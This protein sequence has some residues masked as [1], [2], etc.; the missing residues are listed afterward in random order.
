M[1]WRSTEARPS[2]AGFTLIEVLVALSIVALALA[3]IGALVANS[4]RGTR[5]IE[6]N[7]TRLEIARA[8]LTAIP[9]RDRPVP[10]NLSGETAGHLWRVDVL[11]FE[12]GNIGAQNRGAWLP[13]RIVVTVRSP[14]G[15]ALQISTI[16]LQPRSGG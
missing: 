4:T 13:Q 5:S 11:P 6:A 1:F 10:E 2:S 7:L 14:I 8:V 12:S 16:R 15:D 9:E 3:P